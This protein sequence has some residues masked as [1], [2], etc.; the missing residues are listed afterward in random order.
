[1]LKIRLRRIGGKN[2][3][4]YQIILCDSRVS[5]K[6]K[7]IEKLGNY[8]PRV[9]PP[10][11][12]VN[13]ERVDYWVKKGAQLSDRIESLLKKIGETTTGGSNEVTG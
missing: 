3:P 1:M 12:E 8:N 4:Y 13:R 11:F 7:F 10:L 5:A 6:G 9:N 2:K